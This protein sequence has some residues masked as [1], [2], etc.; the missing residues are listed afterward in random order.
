[1]TLRLC[2]VLCGLLMAC[3]RTDGERSGG[4]AVG[5]T[6][7]SQSTTSA[8]LA[9]DL[10][11]V[12]QAR[13]YF[14]HHSVGWNMLEGLEEMAAAEGIDDVQ[15]VLLD[16][17]PTPEPVP[18]GPFFAHNRAGKNK[19]PE[20]KIDEFAKTVRE[21]LPVQ[22]D[23][24]FMKFCYVDFMPDTD[25]RELFEKYRSTMSELSEEYP[26]V[27]FLH[28]TVPLKARPTGIKDRVKRV[29]GMPVWGDDANLKRY[30]FNKL[31]EATYDRD[32]IIDIAGEESTRT[33]G[34]REQ[35]ATKDG[36]TYY[37]M[38]PEYTYDGGHLNDVGKKKVAAEMIRV[39]ARN[40]DDAGE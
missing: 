40:V 5:A 19:D 34:T 32:Q 35:H 16:A 25:T 27:R 39:I 23:V 33:D 29:L 12:A 9:S 36:Q 13:V 38:V 11:K 2:W 15:L 1:M 4:A 24:A 30:E 10:K 20:S 22:P 28:T 14:G 37:S 7:T 17:E 18:E 26:D 3:G 31:L 8:E 6:G 21:G